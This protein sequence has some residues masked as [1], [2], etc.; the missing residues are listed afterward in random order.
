MF[1]GTMST[2][3]YFLMLMSA[4]FRFFYIFF[5]FSNWN[6]LADLIICCIF[7]FSV[8]LTIPCKLQYHQYGYIM[9]KKLWNISL[10]NNF[11]FSWNTQLT[12]PLNNLKNFLYWFHI[13]LA[14]RIV[15]FCT[16]SLQTCCIFSRS[17]LQSSRL[18]I[19]STHFKHCPQFHWLCVSLGRLATSWISK[20]R[21][22]LFTILIW[23]PLHFSYL[24][25]KEAKAIF[26]GLRRIQNLWIEY[27]YTWEWIW[28]RTSMY[29]RQ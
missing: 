1:R 25:S 18:S 20:T 19:A 15:T 8:Q 23:T 24:A 7:Y 14:N 5:R 22:I 13:N 29:P 3:V 17:S 27:Y 16:S 2:I 28:N 12:H 26:Q 9:K 6:S 11:Q 21:R 4:N 10:P